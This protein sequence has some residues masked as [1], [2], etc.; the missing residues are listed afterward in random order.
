MDR[1]RGQ[2]AAWVVQHDAPHDRLPRKYVLRHTNIQFQIPQNRSRRDPG[3]QDRSQL[4]CDHDVQ[5]VVASVQGRDADHE[6]QQNIDHPH[7][8]NVVVR[9]V[10]QPFDRHATGQKWNR[11][12]SDH[13]GQNQGS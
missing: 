11:R 8:G 7:T 5:Q 3:D 9:R 1:Q 4:G 10:P 12:Q 2:P 13:R 6:R